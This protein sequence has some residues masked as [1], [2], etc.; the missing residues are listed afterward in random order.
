LKRQVKP[1]CFGEGFDFKPDGDLHT[2][3]HPVSQ[4]IPLCLTPS[5]FHF[6]SMQI[7]H[8]SSHQIKRNSTWQTKKRQQFRLCIGYEIEFKA[9]NSPRTFLIYLHNKRTL[10]S[11]KTI[12]N[13]CYFASKLF[14]SGAWGGIKGSETNF[15]PIASTSSTNAEACEINL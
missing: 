2:F 15:L 13:L 1:H 3:R 10:T 11:G 7:S 4:H 12:Q 9:P 6:T 14:R 8:C 5:K